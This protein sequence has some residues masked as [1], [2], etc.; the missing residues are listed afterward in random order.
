MAMAM[1]NMV[2]LVVINRTKTIQ[3]IMILDQ[4]HN[5]E[6]FKIKEYMGWR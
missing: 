2:T 3:I 4:R 1:T 5:K 6:E